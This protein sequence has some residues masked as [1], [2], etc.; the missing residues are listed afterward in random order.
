M[1]L[2]LFTT[3]AIAEDTPAAQVEPIPPAMKTITLDV[4]EKPVKEVIQEIAKAT[5]AIILA[6]DLV[7]GNV[8]A[9]V[10]DADVEKAL[11]AVAKSIGVEWRKIYVVQGSVYCK[12]ANALAAQMRTVLSLKF[13][14][15]VI[16]PVGTGGSFVHVQKESTAN[17]MIKNLPPK[18][19]FQVVYLVTDDEKAYKREL[20]DESKKKVAKY[21]DTNKELMEMFLAMS[22]EERTAV[23]R[24]SMNVMNQLGPEGMQEMM[25]SV[26]ELDPEYVGEMN[27]MGMQA[28]LNMD[29]EAR[30]N[31][32]RISIKQQTEM[33]N[34]L[35]PEQQQQL[36]EDIQSIT[37]EMQGGGQ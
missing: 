12:D 36:M 6:E 26:F 5:G 29:P 1:L 16:A 3:I 25:S 13:P 37:A 8:T 14:D 33:M 27:K 35:T 32:L 17:E 18:T 9:K 21:V 2:L 10:K 23:L 31:M 19:G 28:M 11:S 20:K 30:R 15:I 34:S 4:S 7:T 24:E 22:P